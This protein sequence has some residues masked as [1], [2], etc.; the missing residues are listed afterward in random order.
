MGYKKTGSHQN[1]AGK[2]FPGAISSSMNPWQNPR[3]LL[4]GW[5]VFM[6]RSSLET[7]AWCGVC[8]FTTIKSR[9]IKV[10]LNTGFGSLITE[11]ILKRLHWTVYPTIDFCYSSDEVKYGTHSPPAWWY[12]LPWK[13]CILNMHRRWWKNW[14]YWSGYCRGRNAGCGTGSC[15]YHRALYKRK[16]L[17]FQPDAIIGQLKEILTILKNSCC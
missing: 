7:H 9:D 2:Y 14:W 12:R 16:L 5:S 11:G 6:K 15:S 13:H 17:P 10:A 8:F 4:P 3:N 1:N